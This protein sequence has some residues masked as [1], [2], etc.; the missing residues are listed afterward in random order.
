M[1]RRDHF[2][3]SAACAQGPFVLRVPS[4][5]ARYG[6]TVSIEVR[7]PRQLPFRFKVNGQHGPEQGSFRTPGDVENKCAS[8]VVASGVATVAPQSGHGSA[9]GSLVPSNLPPPVSTTV[10]L[11]PARIEE[12]RGESS[13][14]WTSG[15][16]GAEG[17]IDGEFEFTFWGDVGLDFTSVVISIVQTVQVPIPNETAYLAFQA[18]SKRRDDLRRK[19]ESARGEK[20]AEHKA[21]EEQREQQA[22]REAN[23]RYCASHRKRC[24]DEEREARIKREAFEREE[25][26]KAA[27]HAANNADEKLLK[28]YCML[29]KGD[30]FCLGF[31]SR[32]EI[33]KPTE[34]TPPPPPHAERP[35]PKPSE[36]AE[37]IPGYWYWA[38]FWFWIGGDWKVPDSDRTENRTIVAP[39]APPPLV[40]EA[41]SPSPT[42]IAVWADG[43]WAWNATT[44]VWIAGSW[45]VPPQSGLR[46]RRADWI[47]EGVRVR[48]N[49]GGWFP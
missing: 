4:A 19:E 30:A 18:E 17:G 1:I 5:N 28:A 36:H 43:Y 40:V 2:T 21:S 41:R 32:W 7:S 39:M 26:R 42:A 37:W 12:G 23:E 48:F 27:I 14:L 11:V 47:R 13:T 33:E 46:W 29:R 3:S 35:P 49:P 8:A 45:R 6:E 9:R 38:E 16:L 34:R 25:N 31:G 22:I 10:F 15:K 24:E 44:Y 20:E